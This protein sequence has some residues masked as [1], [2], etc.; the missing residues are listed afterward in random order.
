MK[1]KDV[2]IDGRDGPTGLQYI[3]DGRGRH[4]ANAKLAATGT[5]RAIKSIRADAEIFMSYGRGYW[6]F[7]K[8]YKL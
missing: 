3:N 4:A 8:K 2:L 5:I 6:S 1:V 7:E